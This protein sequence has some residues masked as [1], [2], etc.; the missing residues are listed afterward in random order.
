MHIM[1]R[2]LFVSV[3]DNKTNLRVKYT[4][5]LSGSH[6]QEPVIVFFTASVI[7]MEIG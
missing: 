3:Y 5:G 4:V 2:G 1:C 7:L 6:V